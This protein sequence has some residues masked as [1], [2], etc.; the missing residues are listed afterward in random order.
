MKGGFLGVNYAAS[1]LPFFSSDVPLAL[2]LSLISCFLWFVFDRTW[3][4]WWFSTAVT[5]VGSAMV[6]VLGSWGYYRFAHHN[7]W[8]IVTCVPCLLFAGSIA[9]GALGRKLAGCR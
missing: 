2:S 3:R 7:F 6:S 5:V 8:N 1:K 9:V 4:G